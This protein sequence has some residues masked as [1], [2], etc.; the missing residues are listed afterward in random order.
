LLVD[1]NEAWFGDEDL[2]AIVERIRRADPQIA[3]LAAFR[4]CSD[5]VRTRQR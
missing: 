2:S 4:T 3:T 1:P 5:R